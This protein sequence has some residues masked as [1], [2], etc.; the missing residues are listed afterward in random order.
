MRIK[1]NLIREM[2]CHAFDVRKYSM[3]KQFFVDTHFRNK[4][5]HYEKKTQMEQMSNSLNDRYG[6][7]IMDK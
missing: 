4:Q 2:P 6:L 1:K 3:N 7:K 5:I